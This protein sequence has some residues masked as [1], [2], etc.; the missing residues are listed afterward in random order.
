L[1]G[2]PGRLELGIGQRK[3]RKPWAIQL[4]RRVP[5]M[6]ALSGAKDLA[7]VVWA[8]VPSPEGLMGLV[9]LGYRAP[10]AVSASE[11]ERYFYLA[12]STAVAVRAAQQTEELGAQSR[13]LRELSRAFLV[14]QERERRRIALELHD[15]IGNSLT[16]IK[17]NLKLIER[18]VKGGSPAERCRELS[19]VTDRTLSEVRRIIQDLRPSLLDDLGLSP[20][21]STFVREFGRRTGLTVRLSVEGI[22]KRM[23]PEAETAL[24]RVVQEGLT[25][26]AKHSG[27]SEAEVRVARSG[28]WVTATVS[29][30]GRRGASSPATPPGR[31]MT[32]DSGGVGL[33]A[34]EERLAALGGTVTWA[35]TERGMRVV[36]RVPHHLPREAIHGD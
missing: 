6:R 24:Y 20:A 15:E 19:D 1:Q 11:L 28:A 26:V 29:D 2:T 8:P 34:M 3:Q 31:G 22:A 30:N 16:A 7:T 13:R 9:Q 36:A 27:A 25:N 33:A 17:L 23:A 12:Q 14:A 35:R 18:E 4:G 32:E 21:L 5:P 10:R